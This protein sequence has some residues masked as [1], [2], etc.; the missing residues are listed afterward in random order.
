MYY[1]LY[2]DGYEIPSKVANDPEEPSVGR[3]RVDYIPPPHT[4]TSIKICISRVEGKP[5]L[6]DSD[7]FAGTTCDS[8]L[9]E[10]HISFLRTDR[11]GLSPNEPMA[12]VHAVSPVGPGL[13]PNEPIAI[14]Q[15]EIPSI[16][17][18]R[19]LIKNRGKEIYWSAGFLTVN[20]SP[21]TME[22]ANGLHD[23]QVNEHSL[24]ILIFR[25]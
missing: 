7:L 3:I 4:P 11:P 9:K 1:Q 6:V 5:A 21:V 25:R 19:Y 20:F 15:L 18:G 12:I 10:G 14:V 17:D 8:P 23:T 22:G 24:I 16:P 13:S 2:S